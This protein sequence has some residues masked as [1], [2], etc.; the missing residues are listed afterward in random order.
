MIRFEPLDGRFGRTVHGVDLTDGIADSDLQTL[1]AALYDHCLLF[2]KNQKI[3]KAAFLDF[4]RKWGTPI[5]HVLDHLRM[6]GFPELL[7]IGNTG[8]WAKKA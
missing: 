1:S 8:A 6:P 4:G 3:D 7:G 2:L 5:P